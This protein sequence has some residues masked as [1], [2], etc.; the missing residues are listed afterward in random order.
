MEKSFN[1]YFSFQKQIS[2]ET[3]FISLDESKKTRIIKY[4]W[5]NTYNMVTLDKINEMSIELTDDFDERHNELCSKLSLHDCTHLNLNKYSNL[6]RNYL[7]NGGH[8]PDHIVVLE[9]HDLGLMIE[10]TLVTGDKG[11]YQAVND[12]TGFSFKDC[13]LCKTT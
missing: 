6:K 13:I 10:L 3:N 11:M 4:I 5:N 8:S 9:A 2:N 1:N 7:N 12:T